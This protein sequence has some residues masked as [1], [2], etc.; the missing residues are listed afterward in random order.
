M[1]QRDGSVRWLIVDA[2][3]LNPVVL[4]TVPSDSAQVPFIA[5]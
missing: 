3:D 1:S 4:S 2:R 5:G